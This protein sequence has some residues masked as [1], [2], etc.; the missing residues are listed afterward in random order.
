MAQRNADQVADW[1]CQSGERW[2]AHQARLDARLAVFGQAAI[3]AA[4]PATGACGPAGSGCAD[5]K[6]RRHESRGIDSSGPRASTSWT[7]LSRN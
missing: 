6:K 1:N 7:L 5:W 2:V 4:A 3:E